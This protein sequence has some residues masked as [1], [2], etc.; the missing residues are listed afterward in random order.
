MPE[1]VVSEQPEITPSDPDPELDSAVVDGEVSPVAMDVVALQAALDAA[2][3]RAAENLD[4]WQRARADFA[5]YKRRMEGEMVAVRSNAA[6]DIIATF[7]PVLD[8]LDLA[9]RNAPQVD[10][11]EL[12]QWINGVLMVQRKLYGV[13]ERHGVSRI[14]ALGQ[15]FDPN[16]HEAVM[17]EPSE[18]HDSGTV[19]DVLREGYQMGDRVIRPSMVRVAA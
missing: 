13:F 6:A 16:K 9:L 18:T 11:R 1:D 5:N 4:G 7:L 2:E 10:D 12:A 8:D 3:A 17:Q 19:I 14:E 15:P